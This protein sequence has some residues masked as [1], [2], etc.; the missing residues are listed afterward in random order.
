MRIQRP[1][2]Q[3]LV[4]ACTSLATDPRVDR[5]IRLFEPHFDIMA[6][7]MAPPKSR[8]VRFIDLR[9]RRPGRFMRLTSKVADKARKRHGQFEAAYWNSPWVA[10]AMKRLSHLS[11]DCIVANDLQTLP[12]AL[13]IAK[14]R[15]VLADAHEYYPEQKSD[16][17]SWRR[18]EQPFWEYLCRQ[19]LSQAQA[20][21]T[22][23][24]GIARLYLEQFGIRCQCI[25]SVPSFVELPPQNPGASGRKTIR[26]IHHG[27]ADP[28]RQLH[29]MIETLSHLDSR[30]ELALMLVGNRAGDY[31]KFL[32]KY[33]ANCRQ[34]VSFLEPV[35]TRQIA[36]HINAWDIGMFLLPPRTMNYHFT[37]P[38]K[39]FEFIQ[40]RLAL[41]VG[42]STDMASVVTRHRL[43]VVARD[44]QPQTMANCLNRLT[45]KQI[46]DFKRQSCEAARIYCWD[47]VG[48]NFLAIVQGLISKPLKCVG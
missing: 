5:Q 9:F 19:Y 17:P 1:H 45:T 39:F 12:L 32:Q 21:T 13:T 4:L 22:V 47:R 6:A 16:K 30:F 20:V 18:R 46:L 8:R 15:P 44:F 28:R 11:P 36:R 3:L 40:G 2:P 27:I 37:L 7:G 14:G 24:P 43:G 10:N 31:C 35:P 26:I 38:N 25:Q 42:P 34:P 29:L 23:S 41:A 48:P 33:A